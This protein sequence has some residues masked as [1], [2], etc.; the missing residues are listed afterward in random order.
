MTSPILKSRHR[1]ELRA[2]TDVFYLAKEATYG[3]GEPILDDTRK[4]LFISPRYAG[5]PMTTLLSYGLQTFSANGF[6]ALMEDDLR[7][8][9][10]KIQ[11]VMM[12]EEWHSALAKLL[13]SWF[14]RGLS[15]ADRLRTL[16]IIPLRDGKWTSAKLGPVY[17]PMTKGFVIPENLNISVMRPTA[18]SNIAR[19]RLYEHLGV[20]EADVVTVRAAVLRECTTLGLFSVSALDSKPYLHYLYVTHPPGISAKAE[21]QQIVVRNGRGISHRPHETDIYLPGKTRPF[22]PES[23]LAPNG[24]APGFS[25]DFI[26]A[27]Y[28]EDIPEKPTPDHP[29]WERWLFDFVGIRER[30][31]LVNHNGESLSESVLYVHEHL[32]DQFLGLVKYLW[33]SASSS[34]KA[35]EILRRNIKGL[36]AKRLCGASDDISLG[37]TWLPFKNLRDHVSLYMELPEHFPFLKI[38]HNSSDDKFSLEW[39]FLAECFEVGKQENLV[40]YMDILR[41]IQKSNPDAA[42]VSV[43][44]G[45]KIFDLYSA[46]YAKL[47]L[48]RNQ[49]A[50]PSIIK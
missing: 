34:V 18:T 2:I 13:C 45:Q 3:D 24:T 20:S 44:Q 43:S 31:R 8:P 35:N 50:D 26:H 40:F 12:T 30:L 46:I 49:A 19:Q 38:D 9:Y 10:P 4:D 15:E 14:S 21:F 42:A 25:V 48:S 32:P 47:A 11:G 33:R 23:L 28:M 27:M 6:L 7:S 39:S 41:Y 16:P 37:D 36:S 17:L 1:Q 22:S 5:S 29:S